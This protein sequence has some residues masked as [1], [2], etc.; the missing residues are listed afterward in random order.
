MMIQMELS[1]KGGSW[2][3]YKE[4]E[5]SKRQTLDGTPMRRVGTEGTHKGDMGPN[6]KPEI[7]GMILN[8][9]KKDII[10]LKMQWSKKCPRPKKG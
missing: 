7:T 9:F 8:F 2:K 3:K 1:N 10:S 5:E 4:K 6:R